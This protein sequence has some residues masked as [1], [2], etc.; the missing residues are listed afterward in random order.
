MDKRSVSVYRNS[1]DTVGVTTTLEAVIQRIQTGKNGLVE[2]T[3]YCNALAITEPAEY[4]KYKE[5]ELPAVT[6]SGTFPKGKRKAQH[7]SEHSG[8]VTLDIDGLTAEQIPELLAALAQ[9]PYVRLAFVSPS[10]VGI[11]VIVRVDPIPTNDIEHKGAY[12]ACLD[13]FDDLA[14]EY[15]F[16]IDTSGKDC[17]RLC[18]LSHHH[19]A[20]VHT[21]TPPIDWDKAD[22]LTAEKKK[23]ERF[24]ADA[25]IAYTGEVDITALVHIDPNDLDYNQ[26][27]SVITAC[28]QAGLTWQQVD[29][30]SRR[31]GVRYTEGEVEARWQGLRL[32]VSWGAVVNLAK[33]NGYKPTRPKAKLRQQID[34]ETEPTETLDA[35]RENREKATDAFLTAE[36]ETLHV[37][38]VKDSTGTGKTYTL[39]LK[40]QQHGKRTLAQVPHTDLAA[41]AVSIAWEN[42]Y[43]NPF[44]LLG[45]GHNWDDSGIAEIPV[46]ARTAD[47]FEKNNCIMFDAVQEYTE[48]RLA[49]RTYCEHRCEF[50][51]GCLHLAQYEGL[52]DRDFVASC[53]PNLLFDLNMRGYLQSLVTATDEPTD[54]ELAIDAILG[55]QS[56]A[57]PEFDFAIVDDYGINALYTDITFSQKEFKALKKA[58]RGTP[59]ADFAK[60]LLKAFKKKKPT[61]I[62]KALRNAF[63]STAEHHAEI[64]EALT[65][66]ARNGI[67]EY[68][69][70]PKGSQ[71][72]QRLLSEK[73][74]IY[75]DGGTQFI[76]VDFDAYKELTKKGIPTVHPQKIETQEIGEQVRVPHT[77][78]HALIAGVSVEK[79][80]PIWQKGATPIELLDIFLNSIGN[81]KNAPINRTFR[82]GD[83]PKPVLTFSIPPQ[84]PAGILPHIAMLSAT[85]KPADTQH[86]F[87]GQ[88]VTFSEHTGGNLQWADGVQVYQFQD[89]RLTAGSVFEYPKDSDGKRK[90]QETPIGLTATA[91][92]RLAKLNDWAKAVEGKTAF[93]SYKEFID[94]PFGEAVEGFDIVTHFDRVA[95]LNFDDLKFL[96]V[97]GYPK[98]KHEILMGHARKQCASDN[99]PLPKADLSLTDDNGKPISEYIQLTEEAE[100]VE[101]GISITER[102]YKD[103]R[104]EKIRHQLAT[105]KLEQ[106]VGRARLPVWTDT[107]TLIFTDAPIGNITDRATLFST[108][109]FN[110]AETHSGLSEAMDRIQDAEATGDVKTVMETK[111]VSER[112]ARR[113]T[114]ATRDNKKAERDKQIIAL[115]QQ[116]KSQREIRDAL[117]I[118]L[119]TVNKVLKG[120]QKRTWPISTYN[121]TCPKMN[122]PDNPDRPCLEGDS[123]QEA[124]IFRRY[125]AGQT[126]EAIKDALGIGIATVNRVL[127]T[128][129]F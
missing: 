12:Q 86:A 122:T 60:Q 23:N 87:D 24:E 123:D 103:P 78:T 97:F 85:T 35:N 79:L 80:T 6:F 10:G 95:G 93:I 1:F 82:A 121:W 36:P 96:V 55:T 37:F 74:V 70:R 38:L 71:E 49:P 114:E 76:P 54:E 43:K 62:L 117:G 13:F 42:G 21:E 113:Q 129:D 112:T 66:H 31:G 5:K 4:K 102:R 65:Q 64:S 53:T 9:N 83:P 34:A 124:E 107:N 41:Q 61:G 88:P 72:S 29:L 45:R 99:T 48:K 14:T 18:Y 120:V 27:L 58:W 52:G 69:A 101:N 15:G 28:K 90:L 84:A 7:L 51:D 116:G 98:V 47:L 89:A 108:A 111:Q 104:L 81:D 75:S 77:P 115:H 67:V 8:D 30:W 22:W 56:E 110:L 127:N 19:T 3:R 50:R 57:T 33:E 128:R 26:W 125:D 118:S 2:K 46:E 105:E 40:S 119:G 59:T 68:A 94:E 91:E 20:I 44:H 100:Y 92:N 25:K 63:E 73:Q 11:K 32:D 39:F 17:S 126:Q 16:T 109:A 106:A